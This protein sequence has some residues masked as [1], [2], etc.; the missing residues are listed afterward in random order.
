[1][2]RGLLI[3]ENPVQFL[4]SQVEKSWLMIPSFS[5]NFL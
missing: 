3:V 1:L 5:N 4:K 2:K